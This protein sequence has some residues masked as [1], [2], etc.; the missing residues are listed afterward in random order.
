M[1]VYKIWCGS[2]EAVDRSWGWVA[3]AKRL[4]VLIAE[5]KEGQRLSLAV[6]TDPSVMRLR[7]G[8]GVTCDKR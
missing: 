4:L 8:N 7:F 3:G 1:V 6:D 2:W 5:V